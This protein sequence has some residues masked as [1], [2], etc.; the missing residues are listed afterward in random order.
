MWRHSRRYGQHS[1]NT[2]PVGPSHPPLN[3]NVDSRGSGCLPCHELRFV[4]RGKFDLSFADAPQKIDPTVI[5]L[6]GLLVL[7]Y[8]QWPAALSRLTVDHVEQRGNE[9]RLRLGREPIVLP[10]P[11][12][13][14]V[15]QVAAT[16]HGKAVIGDQGSSPWLF[17]GGQPGRPISAF[18]LAERLRQ[19][20]INSARGAVNL[21][22]CLVA[23]RIV[24]LLAARWEGLA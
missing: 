24:G 21:V 13:E 10:E 2:D 17:P 19:L 11:L 8:A 7:L 9:V 18:G 3:V 12:A 6:A 23:G 16:R 1:D 22:A 14:L 15:L 20:G 5:E 4:S